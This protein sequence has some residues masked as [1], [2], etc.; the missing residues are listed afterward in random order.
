MCSDL[1]APYF[2]FVVKLDLEWPLCPPHFF[3]CSL[4]SPNT[5]CFQ[6]RCSAV[7]RHCGRV[8]LC[9]LSTV[10]LRP[11]CPWDSPGK[12]NAVGCVP[13]PRGS[14]QPRNRTHVSRLSCTAGTEPPHL[15][16]HE[17]SR[18]YFQSLD[19][20]EYSPLVGLKCSLL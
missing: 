14:S 8:R 16:Q 15:K 9:N 20:I 1:I 6:A 17:I 4:Y 3:L 11:H 10:A 7:L 5:L 12:N 19:F 13:H 2:S 18:E